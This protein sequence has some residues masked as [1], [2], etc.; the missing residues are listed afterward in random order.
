MMPMK[1]SMPVLK[2]W[3]G[4]LSF[5]S[6]H[7][8]LKL[9]SQYQHVYCPQVRIAEALILGSSSASWFKDVVRW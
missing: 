1:D 4:C 3:P 2:R 6:T 7:A 8:Y 5:R 9:E